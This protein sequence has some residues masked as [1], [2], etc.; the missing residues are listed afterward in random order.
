MKQLDFIQYIARELSISDE[1]SQELL[2]EFSFRLSNE[3]NET[4]S[5][6]II[7][8]GTL[9]KDISG[10]SLELDPFFA[11]EI[12]YKYAGMQPIVISDD[13]NVGI[14]EDEEPEGDVEREPEEEQESVVDE[15]PDSE[16]DREA[17]DNTEIEVDPEPEEE[18]EPEEEQ[19]SVVDEEPDS[20][21]DREADDN[22]EVEV[23]P[24]PEEEREP[25][26][27]VALANGP[28]FEV[29]DE[30]KVDLDDEAKARI[31]KRT[32]SLR[33]PKKTKRSNLTP[34]YIGIVVV[35]IAAVVAGW[36]FYLKPI[37]DEP[38]MLVGDSGTEQ[39][40]VTEAMDSN[41]ISE[42]QQ[43]S[44]V[45]NNEKN[46]LEGEAS[47]TMV[48]NE[49]STIINPENSASR[50][51]TDSV[52]SAPILA[53]NVAE[54]S[55]NQPR[56]GL[57]GEVDTRANDGYTLVL[58]SLSNRQSAMEKYELYRSA[59]YRSLLSPVNSSRFGLMW[60]VSIGQFS[61]VEQALEVAKEL[62][63]EIIEDYFITKI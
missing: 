48:M 12:N 29:E 28:D 18:R 62:P 26:E 36:Q 53:K 27:K 42:E 50:I 54:I 55:V 60:R 46:G 19:E 31:A 38:A 20:E 22:T 34:I 13:F 7:G 14:E 43:P 47:G 16:E 44:A 21:E 33:S 23:D 45:L 32:V 63:K 24:E 11:I 51:N 4:A 59:G 2:R 57:I 1:E 37:L 41:S 40:N 10:I 17:N 3:L 49:E 56:Y 15:E 25:E 30:P 5:V 61:T 6:Q 39:S 35:F 52:V 58:F 8:L 9:I